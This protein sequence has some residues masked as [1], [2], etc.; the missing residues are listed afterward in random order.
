VAERADVCEWGGTFGPN[1]EVKARWSWVNTPNDPP[2]TVINADQ[3]RPASFVDIQ[4]IWGAH[5]TQITLCLNALDTFYPPTI[6]GVHDFDVLDGKNSGM[7]DVTKADSKTKAKLWLNS[8]I[9]QTQNL[10]QHINDN[11]KVLLFVPVASASDLDWKINHMDQM[12]GAIIKRTEEHNPG[13]FTTL[14]TYAWEIAVD[15]DSVAHTAAFVV[16]NNWWNDFIQKGDIS[17]TYA[18]SLKNS[19]EVGNIRLN[20]TLDMMQLAMA[21]QSAISG[22]LLLAIAYEKLSGDTSLQ[23]RQRMFPVEKAV[24]GTDA[25]WNNNALGEIVGWINSNTLLK[26]NMGIF[27]AHRRMLDPTNPN[28]SLFGYQVAYAAVQDP[29]WMSRILNCGGCSVILA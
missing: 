11:T 16:M 26:N 8:W 7:V 14:N 22:D 3:L 10:Y 1:G 20:S 25:W 2:A 28:R 9:V 21:Q 29:T 24:P 23:I 15:A 4:R 12:P 13:L 17:K 18:D 19:S 27:F 5:S 6:S